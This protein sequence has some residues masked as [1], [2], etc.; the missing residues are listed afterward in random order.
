MEKHIDISLTESYAMN[1]AAS[2]SGWYFAHPNS[3]YF[4]V[5]KI[6]KEQIEDYAKRKEVA[7]KEI[8]R[9]LAANLNYNFEK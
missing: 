9:W 2:V 5:G 3:Q 4:S 7:V 1:P 6:T 8:E